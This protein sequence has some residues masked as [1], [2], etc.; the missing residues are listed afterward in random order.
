MEK[1]LEMDKQGLSSREIADR[2][3]ADGIE[4]SHMAVYRALKRARR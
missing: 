4:T 2:L 3:R 1:V